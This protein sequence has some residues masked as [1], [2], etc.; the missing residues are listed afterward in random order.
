MQNTISALGLGER[1]PD[2]KLKAT[3]GRTY[4]ISSF[5]GNRALCLIFLANHCPYVAAWEGRIFA[6]A[7]DYSARGVAFAG[8]SSNDVTRFPQ[9]GPEGMAKRGYPFPYLHD[10]AQT[11]ARAYGATRTPEVFLFDK[12][13]RLRYHGA[14]DS[15]WE[16]EANAEPYLRRALDQLL[17]DRDLTTPET[18]PLGCTIKLRDES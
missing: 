7:R 5:D 17:G 9:D 2:F 6:I 10:E 16:E 12:D 1:A 18:R 11:T 8:I 3:D 13:R 4:S 15:D 14:V